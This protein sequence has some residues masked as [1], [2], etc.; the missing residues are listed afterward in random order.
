MPPLIPLTVAEVT[1]MAGEMLTAHTG[2]H[3][4]DKKTAHEFINQLLFL[5]KKISRSFG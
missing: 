4:I 2:A 5:M 3:V 1:G